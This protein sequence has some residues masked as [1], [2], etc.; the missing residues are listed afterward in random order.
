MPRNNKAI[1]SSGTSIYGGFIDED[2][3]SDWNDLQKRVDIIQKMVDGLAS[4]TAALRAIKGPLLSA[5]YFIQ[6][7]DNIKDDVFKFAQNQFFEYQRNGFKQ[8]LVEIYTAI[9]YGFCLFEKVFLFEKSG[10]YNT[11]AIIIPESLLLNFL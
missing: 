11:K 8:L 7:D 2:Y 10:Y 1:G 5:K 3:Q 9:E 4:T 6:E